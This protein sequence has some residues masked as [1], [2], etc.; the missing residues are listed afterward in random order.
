MSPELEKLLWTWW[1]RDTAEPGER[2]QR[3]KQLES[4]I[5]AVLAEHPHLS[6]EEFLQA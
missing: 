5:R 4:M 1:E 2:A 6:R 3:H